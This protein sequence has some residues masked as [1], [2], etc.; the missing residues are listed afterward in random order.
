MAQAATAAGAQKFMEEG[1]LAVAAALAFVTPFDMPI[2]PVDPID[3][4][5]H[6]GPCIPDIEDDGGPLVP[7][8]DQAPLPGGPNDV[9]MPLYVYTGTVQDEDEPE[10]PAVPAAA[11]VVTQLASRPTEEELILQDK[12]DHIEEEPI[13][14]PLD[15]D[16]IP[17]NVDFETPTLDTT[18]LD[19]AISDIKR[20]G[21]QMRS[22][23]ISGQAA[24]DRLIEIEGALYEAL[25]EYEEQGGD[26]NDLADLI[27]EYQFRRSLMPSD[28]ANGGGGGVYPS[29]STGGSPGTTL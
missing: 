28:L 13:E 16:D 14:V 22:G 9:P 6:P 25:M 5:F 29:G 21:D 27:A 20:L 12:L 17:I 4:P 3:H 7:I 26:I 10:A 23:I 11:G 1:N 2:I 8:P 19:T 18:F 15:Y 24:L